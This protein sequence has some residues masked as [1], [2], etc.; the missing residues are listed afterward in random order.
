MSPEI[1]TQDSLLKTRNSRLKTMKFIVV[2]CFGIV[3]CLS[4]LCAQQ[5]EYFNEH[6]ALSGEIVYRTKTPTVLQSAMEASQLS[7]EMEQFNALLFSINAQS[8]RMFP[9]LTAPKKDCRN[10]IDFTQ[11]YRLTYDPR[12]ITLTRLITL[13]RCLSFIEYAEPLYV[14][15]LMALPNDELLNY[16]WYMNPVK[17]YEAW[18][19]S[20]G[21]GNE[22]IVI[23]IV[24]SGTQIDHDD[25]VHQVAYNSAD[26]VNGIDDDGD[27]YVD[28][29]C[30]W[31][32]GSDDNNPNPD[33]VAHGTNVAGLASAQVN[34][35]IGIAGSGYRCKFLPI[36]IADRA[37]NLVRSYEGVMYAAQNGCSIINCSWGSLGNYSEFAREVVQF[38]TFNCNALVVAA[39]GNSGNNGVFYPA[40][41]PFVISVAGSVQDDTKWTGSN[42]NYFVDVCAP[43]G[44]YRSTT[45]GNRYTNLS[46]GTSYSAP[47]A[48]GVAALI[49]A[50]FPH[51]TAMQVGEQL[52]VNADNIY[53]VGNNSNY[54]YQLGT[55][56][57][58]ALNALTNTESPSIRIDSFAVRNTKELKYVFERGDTLE[59]DLF[60]TN[61]LAELP[62][63]VLLELYGSSNFLSLNTITLGAMETMETKKFTFNVRV[64]RTLNS[65]TEHYFRLAIS[66]ILYNDSEHIKLKL[67]PAN[68]DFTL[69]NFAATATANGTVGIYNVFAPSG[70]GLRYK[71]HANML[72]DAGLL[73]ALNDN[74]TA[75]QIRGNRNYT[76]SKNPEVLQSD[77]VDLLIESKFKTT[78]LG[79]DITQYIYGWERIDALIHEYRLTNTN[80]NTLN[81]VRA[82]IFANWIIGFH[83]YNKV[84]Y[85]DSLKCAVISGVDEGGF[86]VGIMP[87]HYHKSSL[88]AYDTATEIEEIPSQDNFT[89]HGIWKQLTATKTTAG[90]GYDAG[91][92]GNVNTSSWCTIN[93]IEPQQTDTMRYAIIG[94]NTFDDILS[95]A[96]QLKQHY[97]TDTAKIPSCDTCTSLSLVKR[98]DRITLSQTKNAIELNAEKSTQAHLRISNVL[99]TIMEERYHDFA[100][101]AAQFETTDLPH[102]VYIVTAYNK[103]DYQ[104]FTIVITN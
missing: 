27:G 40:S 97:L 33:G 71:E 83:N 34:N 64:N 41:Y 78:Q 68:Y 47:I 86:L 70:Y 103:K 87:L 6:K 80:S 82:G 58:N 94:G 75:A 17:L 15:E 81:N 7:D 98:S 38:V 93:R 4:T 59:I 53:N 12:K 2:L 36:K 37:G 90:I 32:F 91:A 101:G 62:S 67:N 100:Q 1:F 46:G 99:G 57:I 3:V 8:E 43:S 92:A 88:F 45:T 13:L 10:C 73:L 9:Q 29:Y 26:P 22:E 23:G 50:K 89:S 52:R 85:I 95:T 16:Q 74:S 61:Y 31:D 76:T 63:E 69:G 84:R 42:F 11:V 44:G 66:S 72:Y 35:E 96:S 51:Y 56:R 77:S 104:T 65:D 60:C 24:D 39:A 25:L 28:N 55:G 79:I 5:F 102:G 21:Q 19:L 48:S 30:G 54:N 20:D 49:K 18:E 14:E